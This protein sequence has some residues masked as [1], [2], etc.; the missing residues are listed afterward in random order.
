MNEEQSRA[1]VEKALSYATAD[2]VEVSF[3]ESTEK[4]TRFA[5][6]A[7]I[8]SVSSEGRS[9]GVSVAFGQKVGRATTNDISDQGLRAVIERAEAIARH[10]EPDTE[11]L[12]PPGPQDYPK[13]DGYRETTVQLSH[14]DRARGLAGAIEPSAAA[15][16]RAAGSY[17]T[18]AHSS[19]IGN[20]HG[21]FGYHRSTH[22]DYVHTVL[23]DNSSGWASAVSPDAS[24]VDPSAVGRVA[25][26]KAEAAK[27]PIALE[28]GA[29]TVVMEP[30]A[31]SGI[32]SIAGWT[33]QA[34]SAHEGRSAW[35]NREGTQVGVDALT[36]RTVPGCPELPGSP[37]T[38]QGLASREI[39]W[40]DKG[41]LE[42]LMYDRFWAQKSGHAVTGHPS[43]LIVSG[44]DA[45][46]DDLIATVERGVLIT[47]F[48][49]I[50]FVDPMTLMITG[51][52]RDG[53][54][55]IEDG[56][57]TRGLRN[58]RFNDSPLRIFQAIRKLGK[59][60]PT[61][62]HGPIVAPPVL[63]EDFHFTSQTSF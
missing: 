2:E 41:R 12:A 51:M 15:G 32:L 35:T 40:I 42:T 23:T 11:Y 4:A 39:T 45:S 52:T 57:V 28:P 9:V 20:G 53:L 37:W 6:N 31:F 13:V 48:W 16:Y 61:S 3:G 29:Y 56:K 21:L 46:T 44:T 27:D 26:A 10:A 43:N 17:T 54:F 7:I 8:Q 33:M 19:A 38:Q 5:N 49:Y 22:A 60:Q 62:L 18:Y 47:R 34:K 36:L 1:I 25:F 24:R 59:P 63:V 30:S 55:L 14:E 50:R 58:M